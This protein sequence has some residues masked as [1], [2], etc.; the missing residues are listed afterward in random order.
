MFFNFALA[1][2]ALGT[3]AAFRIANEARTAADYVFATFLP[4]IPKT[5]YSITS[6]NMT[7]RATMAGLVG[8]DSPYPPGGMIELSTFME[9]SAKIANEVTLTEQAI[10][11]LQDMLLRLGQT[12]GDSTE[13]LAREALNF[14]DKVVVQPHLDTMEWMRGQALLDQLNWTFG[15]KTLQVSYGVP[16][17]NKVTHRTG[18]AG[19]GGSASTFWSDLRTLRRLLKNNVRAIVAHSETIDM[20][21]YNSANAIA[22]IS[23]VGSVYTMRKLNAQG[24]F[25]QDVG[26]QFVMIAYDKEGDMMD[27]ADTSKT[28]KVP[29]MPKG[30]ILG[31]AENT[32]S[33]YSVG[34]GST[35]DPN[36]ENA[37]GYTHIAPTVE[38]GGRP[39]RWSDLFTPERA[40][41]QLV[42]RGVTNGLPVIEAPDK[43]VV[44]STEMV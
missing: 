12:G 38:G 24:Q 18:T 19:Y 14:L 16:A 1:L 26:D 41:W 10:R 9:R 5:S 25:T 13:T 32:R 4:E 3:G 29:F 8:M 43:I 35:E 27:L 15:G 17:A 6:G 33:G 36:R 20:I 2:A 21:R 31:I 42:G 37:L 34:E 23:Q 28:I 40:P 11:E 22:T 44:L 7:V 30:K 39:G